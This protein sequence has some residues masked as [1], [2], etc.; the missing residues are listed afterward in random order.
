MGPDKNQLHWDAITQSYKFN[1]RYREPLVIGQQYV[2][3]VY[4][5]SPFTERLSAERTFAAD[6]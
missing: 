2:L 5:T 6:R 3:E 4:F 1:L